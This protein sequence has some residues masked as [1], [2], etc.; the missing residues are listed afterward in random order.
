MR[1]LLLSVLILSIAG[2]QN[3]QFYSQTPTFDRSPSPSRPLST[4]AKRD[5]VIAHAKLFLGTPYRLGGT[6]HSG[7]DCS[8][9]VINAFGSINLKLP[10]TSAQQ[11]Q[12]GR[13]ISIDQA[14]PGDLI[15]F[16]TERKG[17][18]SHAGIITSVKEG[19]R[20][21]HSSSSRGVIISDLQSRYWS[22]HYLSI[23]QIIND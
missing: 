20:F 5:Q 18:I 8:G 17:R 19:I 21:I 9:L 22:R 6:S 3:K 16:D 4:S 11:G 2:C 7:I 15:F 14:R 12:K 10:R 13:A 23:R 1:F